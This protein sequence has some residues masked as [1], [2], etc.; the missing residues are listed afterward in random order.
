MINT[1][2][3]GEAFVKFLEDKAIGTFGTDLFLGSLPIEAPDDA[4]LVVVGGGNPEVVTLDGGMIKLYTFNI[5]HR[6]L[7]GKELERELFSLEEALNCASCVNLS[8]FETIYSRATNFAQ[9]V[10]LENEDRR[11]GLLQ[12]QV[13]L[14]KEN[15]QIS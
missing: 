15:I 9:D 11:I 10:D 8:G 1:Q 6:S 4:W 7:A 2:T 12:A 13:R 14:F 3:V 5:Y